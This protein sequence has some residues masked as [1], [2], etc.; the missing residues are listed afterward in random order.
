MFKSKLTQA[1]SLLKKRT[2]FTVHVEK[3]MHLK[4]MSLVI[5][6]PSWKKEKTT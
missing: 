1:M 4:G 6:I 3:Y 5:I 2:A